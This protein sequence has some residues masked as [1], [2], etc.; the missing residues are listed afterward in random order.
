MIISTFRIS[1]IVFF[2]LITYHL[3]LITSGASAAGPPN[4]QPC[5]NAVETDKLTD[6]YITDENRDAPIKFT[7]DQA[8]QVKGKRDE[9]VIVSQSFSFTVDFSNLQ[10]LFSTTNSN[11]LEGKFQDDAHRLANIVNLSSQNF[12]LFHGPGQKTSAKI[13]I[14]DLRKKYME[15]VYNKPTLL[16]ST[17]KYTD[18]EGKGDPKTIYDLVGEFGLPDPPEANEDR[19]QWLATW[20]RYWEKIPTAYSEFYVGK[21]EFKQAVGKETIRQFEAGKLCLLSLPRVIEFIL[22]QFWRTT[23]TSDQLNQMIVPYAAQSFRDHGTITQQADAGNILSKALSLCKKLLDQT[24]EALLKSLRRVIKI[25]LDSANPIKTA[26]AQTD[27]TP[28]GCFKIS[29]PAK[30]GNEKYCALP[31][32]QLLPG[33]TCQNKTDENKLDQ[34]NPNVVCTFNITWIGEVTID[35]ENKAKIFDHCDDNGDGTYTCFLPL[36]IWPVFRVPWLAEIWN[37]T[38]YSDQAET[39]TQSLQ[40]TGRPGVYSFFTPQA[41]GDYFLPPTFASLVQRCKDGNQ[42]AC[43]QTSKIASECA[44]GDAE[45]LVKYC[46][47]DLL[48]KSLPGKQIESGDEDLK[49]RFIGA[50]DC[51]KEIVRDLALKPKALQDSLGVKID[52]GQQ[53]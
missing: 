31:A 34:D 46:L 2:L 42:A 11:Y 29:K 9:D 25:S 1:L 19:T 35:P 16:E 39:G 4:P 44:Q 10:A 40:E 32:D 12:N 18:I 23:A 33:E 14:D 20:G 5:E 6:N 3:S 45:R 48:S 47:P 24:P 37:S 43:N 30:E 38:L 15:Y 50:T 36:K 17:N 51:G 53:P 22:P 26:F 8:I 28:T 52:C 7:D 27:T 13:L 41:V 21:L 49:K